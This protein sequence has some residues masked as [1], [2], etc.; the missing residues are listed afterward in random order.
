MGQP[1]TGSKTGT[2]RISLSTSSLEM[3]I[4]TFMV[5]NRDTQSYPIL[6]NFDSYSLATQASA[7]Y[8]VSDKTFRAALQK[9]LPLS[10]ELHATLTGHTVNISIL[11]V[12]LA[13][14]CGEAGGSESSGHHIRVAV[15]SAGRAAPASAPC[16][17]PTAP[18]ATLRPSMFS[19]K[20][21]LKA[22]EVV[23]QPLGC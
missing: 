18:E 23:S 1:V 5:Q 8:G 3:L 14:E 17:N 6:G 22:S 4:G 15:R 20:G 10:T 2:T 19:R 21:K 11:L 9:G 7:E 16:R 13:C 12:L